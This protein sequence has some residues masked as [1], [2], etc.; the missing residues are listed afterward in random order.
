M[1]LREL[2]ASTSND[3]SALEERYRAETGAELVLD[4]FDSLGGALRLTRSASVLIG[5]HDSRETLRRSLASIAGSSL[6]LSYPELLEV[7]VVD[8]GSTD[9]TWELLAELELDL[10]LHCIR[11]ERGGLTSAHNT[12]LAFAS[13]DVVIFSDADMVHTPFALEELLRRHEVLPAVTLLGF[14]FDIDAG[15]PR[16]PWELAPAFWGDFRLSFP[17]VPA[18]ICGETGHLKELGHGR[19]VAMTNGARYD[20]PSMVVGA[21][22]SIEREVLLA[23]GGSEERLRGWGC[24]DSL[25]GARS[26]ALGNAIVP[27]YGAAS[28]HVAHARRDRSESD[29]FARNIRTATAILDEPFAPPGGD[30][31]AGFGARALEHLERMTSPEPREMERPHAYPC[32]IYT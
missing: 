23:M 3:Y 10:R 28:A 32:L 18:S 13:G 4:P 8:D 25:I 16:G 29:E 17:G 9:G 2:L 6:N 1:T 20:L 14:R 15:D 19:R 22:F 24:E 30:A 26:T 11:Q 21:F 12:G 7:I 31:I 5:T 27:V